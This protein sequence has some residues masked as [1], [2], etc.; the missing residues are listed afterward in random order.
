MARSYLDHSARLHSF[1]TPRA[2]LSWCQRRPV[3]YDAAMRGNGGSSLVMAPFR[4]LRFDAAAVGALASVIS[5]PYDVLDADTVRNLEAGNR[6]N[7]VRLILSRHYERPYLAVRKR[8]ESWRDQGCLV[9]DP[10]PSL[11]LYQYTVE[12]VTVRGLIGLVGLRDEGERVI[13]PHEDVMPGPVE[14]RCALMR[15]TGTNLEPILLVHQGT[16]ALRE[17]LEQ[18]THGAPLADIE[19]R[20]G[21]RHQLWALTDGTRHSVVAE[22]LAAGQA[23]IADGHHRYASYL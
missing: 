15:T 4:G 20:D 16:R 23:L 14:D 10:V 8:L 2:S 5:P 18:A 19:E 6:R 17:L 9:P 13:L 3:S 7:I 12:G 11:Y 21:S 1:N 22:Q